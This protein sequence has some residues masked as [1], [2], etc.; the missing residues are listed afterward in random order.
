MARG[1][2]GERD[3]GWWQTGLSPMC[4][5]TLLFLEHPSVGTSF[6]MAFASDCRV[7]IKSENEAPRREC[8]AFC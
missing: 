5:D 2:L 1:D 4:S 6:M 7:H 3:I 8:E